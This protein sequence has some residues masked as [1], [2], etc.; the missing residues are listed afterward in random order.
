ME[1]IP[2]GPKRWILLAAWLAGSLVLGLLYSRVPPNDDN[3]VYDYIGWMASRGGVLYVD[4]ADNNWPGIILLHELSTSLFGNTLWSWHLLDYLLMVAGCA[5]LF[6]FARRAFGGAAALVVVPLYQAMYVSQ[7]SSFSGQRDIVLAPFLVLSA[8]ALWERIDSGKRAWTAAQGVGIA[9]A[10]LIRPTFLLLAPLLAAVDFLFRKKTNRSLSTMILDHALAT[11]AMLATFG[12][13]ALLGWRSGATREW[14]RM[15]VLF[16]LAIDENAGET[17]YTVVRYF[18]IYALTSWHWILA[19]TGIGIYTHWRRRPLG[20]ALLLAIAV[21]TAVSVVVQKRGYPYHWGPLWPVL[22]VLMAPPIAEAFQ[23]LFHEPERVIRSKSV[24]RALCGLLCLVVVGGLGKKVAVALRSPAEWM[25]GRISDREFYSRYS[26]GDLAPL[27]VIRDLSAYVENTTPPDRS[28][29]F[30]GSARMVNFLAKRRSFSRFASISPL[31]VDRNAEP[32][33]SE[34]NLRL[35]REF[36]AELRQGLK[37]DPPEMFLLQ[38]D[39]EAEGYFFLPTVRKEDKLGY[40]LLDA[41]LSGYTMEK[42]FG[43]IECWRRKPR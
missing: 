31:I 11:A 39:P 8:W 13:V 37:S 16:N 24:H 14:Y 6:F 32:H 4:A 35:F 33:P 22:A 42:K 2:A 9:L 26:T 25:T 29:F 27:D 12:L 15:A 36:D 23:S 34:T 5:P 17:H 7:N 40:I 20:L 3:A 19:V 1:G 41:V 30:W 10:V 43:T 28:V 18:V 21:T 38:K